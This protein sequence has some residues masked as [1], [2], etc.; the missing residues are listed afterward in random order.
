MDIIETN[1]KW[2]LFVKMPNDKEATKFE[3]TE[4]KNN[5]FVC[6]NDSIDFPKK[7]KYWTDGEKIKAKIE[8]SIFSTVDSHGKYTINLCEIDDEAERIG[9]AIKLA[10]LSQNSQV[11]YLMKL[12]AS[13]INNCLLGLNCSLTKKDVRGEYAIKT[14][15]LN[16]WKAQKNLDYYSIEFEEIT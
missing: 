16:V 1:G 11:I 6:V 12:D 10:K 14:G 13:S 8:N 7:I 15:Y 4:L 5:E 3:M 2:T 9:L